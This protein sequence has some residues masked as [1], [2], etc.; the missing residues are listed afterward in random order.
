HPPSGAQIPVGLR[1]QAF[2]DDSPAA[3]IDTPLDDF[4]GAALGPGA[5]SLAFGQDGDRYYCYFPMP[6]H[7]RARLVV[8]NDGSEAVNGWRLD[9]GS[10]DGIS[11]TR[12]L[13]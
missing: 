1:L 7:R 12:P 10:V 2:W 9:V 4:F 5:R 8:R 11:A 6:F 13:Y 3:H